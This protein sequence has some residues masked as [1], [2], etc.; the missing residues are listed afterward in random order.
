MSNYPYDDE[1]MKYDYTLHGYV[2][3]TKGVLQLLG[4][5]LDTYLDST[6]DADPSTLPDRILRKISRHV[7]NYIYA[8]SQNVDFIER[9]LATYPPCRDM[10]RE[11]LVAEVDYNLYNGTFWNYVDNDHEYSKN[12]SVDTN[13]I[14]GRRL[15]NGICVLYQGTLPF[16]VPSGAFHV[17]Y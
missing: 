13:A 2:L 4:E 12:V 5:N 14:L 8:H 6:G 15:P 16:G 10:I 1:H 7:Y 11:A 9:M 3:T 17:G